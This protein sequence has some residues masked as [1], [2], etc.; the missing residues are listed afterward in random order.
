MN[1]IYI[2]I[3]EFC[4]TDGE[5]SA[6]VCACGSLEKASEKAQEMIASMVENTGIDESEVTPETRELE[7]DGWSYAVRVVEQEVIC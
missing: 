7:G 3:E 4:G 2:V 1:K 5:F 6:D